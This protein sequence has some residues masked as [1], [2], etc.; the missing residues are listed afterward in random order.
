MSPI[1]ARLRFE[2]KWACTFCT[3]LSAAQNIMEI[4][5]DCRGEGRGGG[6]T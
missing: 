6:G 2:F 1:S 4:T 5:A 3:E